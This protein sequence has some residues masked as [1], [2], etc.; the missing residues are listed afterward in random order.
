MDFQ[1][2][3]KDVNAQ[4]GALAAYTAEEITYICK[5]IGPRPCGEEGETKAQEYLFGKLAPYADRVARETYKVHPEAFMAFVPVA[6]SLLLGATALNL[7]SAFKKKAAA[8][9]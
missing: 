4:I 2:S 1:H 6:G 5:E 8:L 9:G 3:A 7:V